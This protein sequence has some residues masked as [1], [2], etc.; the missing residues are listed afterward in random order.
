MPAP[1]AALLRRF[2]IRTRM[3]GAIAMVLALFAVVGLVGLAGGARLKALNTDFMEHS[4]HEMATLA[5]VR[6][7]LARVLVLEKSMVIDYEDGVAVL[8]HRE[9]WKSH[10][11]AAREALQSMTEGEDDADN[12]VA[13]DAVTQLKEYE[14]RSQPVL[15]NVQ[16]GG[17][18]SG[19]VADRMLSRA[20]ES[21]AA[22]MTSV[23]QVARL[24]TD[25][26]TQTQREF[27]RAML[28]ILAAFCVTLGAVVL[29]VVPLTLLNS[30]SITRPISH[31]ARVASAIADGDLTSPIRI[32]GR[33]EA[34]ELLT[35]LS[36][37]QDSLRRIVSRVHEAAQSIRAASA[38]VAKGNADL[39]HRTEQTAG[40][41]QQTASSMQQLT[42]TVQSNAGSAEKAR[43]LTLTAA[44]VAGRGGQVVAQVVQTMDEI[45]GSSHRIADIVGTIDGI[46]FQTN[47]LA[48]NAAVEAARAGEQ[49]RGFAVVAGEV[50][51]LAQR[52]A[53]AAR[54]IKTLIGASVDKVQHGARQVGEAGQTMN[55][56]VESVQSVTA[57]VGEIS[58][59]AAEQSAGIGEV[60]GAVTQLDR[61]TQQNAALVEQSTAA[62]E[63]LQSEAHRLT[64]TVAAFRL[65]GLAVT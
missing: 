20:K 38:E 51:A 6:D 1:F 54:E 44:E 62:A 29:V 27:D 10:L 28:G 25:E 17:Y 8:K 41:L 48:L 18:D 16:N 36:R 22:A 3:R 14:Q 4:I 15:D 32:E 9:A 46:A 45:N 58:A 53:N 57:I 64:E 47:I 43:A 50:R 33:D 23:D 26:V 35:S 60:N 59:G 12:A 55:R 42:G 56:I 19:R 7:E 24:V 2:S 11:A 13:L 52:S 37:M 39:S 65:P 63:Q 31:A 30:H 49:G 5:V 61:M 34:A 21:Y 40:S